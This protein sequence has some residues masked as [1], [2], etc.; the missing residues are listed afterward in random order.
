VFNVELNFTSADEPMTFCEAE[1]EQ[2]WRQAMIDKMKSIEDNGTWELTSLPAGHRA[3]G[4]KWVCKVKRDEAGNIVRHKAR[5]VAKEY[6]QHAGIDFDKVF[7]LVARL[8]SVPVALAAHECWTVY[9]MDVKSAFLNRTLREE[10]YVHQPPGF[11]VAGNKNKVLRLHK[12]LHGLWQAPR[13][14]NA[15]LDATMVEL[16]F[17]RSRSEHGI[18]TQCRGEGRLI[19]G[20]YVDSLIIIGTNDATITEFKTEMENRFPMSDL[21]LLS[22]YLGIEVRQGSDDIFLCQLVYAGK[23]LEC[24]GLSSCNPSAPPMESRLKLSKVDTEE[25]VNVT[26]YRSVIGALH[27]LLHTQP[28]L[29]F[30]VGY[31]SRFMEAPRVDHLAAVKRILQYVAGT[32]DNKLHYTRRENG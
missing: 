4:L 15:K 9:H 2:S 31:L 21:G 24:C 14:W 22:Y 27:Y 23:I 10:V 29:A 8:E 17:Q 16:G 28:D 25:A 32:R 26:E 18:Y 11:V 1:R 30:A 19:V 12:A 20:V 6:V 13:T 3:I 5:L 7:A